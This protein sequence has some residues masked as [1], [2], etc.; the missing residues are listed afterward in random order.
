[1][2][3]FFVVIVLLLNA[4]PAARAQSDPGVPPPAPIPATL[5][6]RQAQEVLEV[7]RDDAK[8][9]QFISVLEGMAKALPQAGQAAMAV[10]P[11]ASAAPPPPV[12]ASRQAAPVPA[13]QAQPAAQPAQ[14]AAAAAAA[15]MPIPLA[16][17]SLGAEILVGAS[18]RLEKLSRELAD[19]ARMLTDFPLIERWIAHLA[20]NR[21]ARAEVLEALWKLAVVMTLSVAAERLALRPLHRVIAALAERAPKPAPVCNSQPQNGVERPRN[22]AGGPRFRR[23][24]TL[25]LVRRIPFALGR[26]AIELLP[27]LLVVAIGY[28]MLG[29]PLGAPNTA[30]LVILAVLNAYMLTR[31]VV[32]VTRAVLAPHT[33]CLRL[34]Y[35]SDAGAQYVVRWVRRMAIIAIF[36]YATAE[37]GL[38]FGLYRVAHDALLKLVSLALHLCLV[39]VVLQTRRR[40]ADAIRA[41]PGATGPMAVLRNRLAAV[42]HIIAIFYLLA[43]WLVWALEIPDG[44]ARLVRIFVSAVVVLT[45]ARLVLVS[46]H[47][48][49][50]RALRI[51]PDLAA[52]Y[53]G[54][55]TR[56][57]RYHPVARAILDGIISGIAIVVLFQAWGL[58]SFSWFAAGALG[59]RLVS[60]LINIGITLLAALLIWEAANAAVQRH[61]AR[62][63]R[64]AQA[65]RSARMRTLLPM[66]RTAML[67]AICLVAGLI[68]LSEI[69]VNIAPLLAGAGVVGLAIG[70]GSQ[71]L[72]QDIITGLFLLLENTMQVGDVVSLGGL[73]GTVENLSIRTIRLRALDGSVHIVPFSAVTTVTNMTRDFGYAL[74]DISVGLNED[75]DHVT[76][77]VRDVA[78][79][80]RAEPRWASAIR[81]DL[82]VLGL[83]KFIDLAYV[84]RVRIQTLPGQR[85]AVA[86]ELNR[87]IK[88]KF[89]ELAI[90][91]PFTSHRVLSNT[92]APPVPAGTEASQTV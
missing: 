54:L 10:P 90:E 33:P 68:V 69:G 18:K 38:L 55:E 15:N 19:G 87:R 40:I 59:G 23:P 36:G 31:L 41:R 4:A 21:D 26:L 78:R 79:G 61:L 8:R 77:V 24:S 66:F 20:R 91:S 42:W 64:D 45:A 73:S 22:Q 85:W 25:L 39:V 72:V 32:T 49:L 75:P 88:V 63:S 62:L 89:D 34:V 6:P 47:N 28:A 57:R 11:P 58:D 17:N 74:L 51:K 92:P 81:D 50:E 27:I 30:R 52:R 67:V 2:L 80:L 16:P 56:A 46:A 83:E 12:P 44:A 13:P 3:R 86:R 53:P 65:A 82:E 35:L 37:V 1:M 84:L 43:L 5:S 9:A 60:A 70:F 14:P 76:E 71:K 7:L 29:T 48:A